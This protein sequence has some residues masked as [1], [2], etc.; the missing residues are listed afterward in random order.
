MP[1]CLA[2]SRKR[3]VDRLSHQHGIRGQFHRR[4]G[5]AG[6]HIIQLLLVVGNLKASELQAM[7]CRNDHYPV[8]WP[9]LAPFHKL[10]KGRHGHPCLRQRSEIRMSGVELSQ[11]LAQGDALDYND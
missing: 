11:L 2:C 9:D 3:P 5:V 4:V 7:G 10:E 1:P 6:R 8:L